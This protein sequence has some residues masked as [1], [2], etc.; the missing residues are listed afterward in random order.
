MCWP[1]YSVMNFNPGQNP[2]EPMG[3]EA[4][5]GTTLNLLL[6]RTTWAEAPRRYPRMLAGST[7]PQIQNCH[8]KTATVCRLVLPTCCFTVATF[9]TVQLSFSAHCLTQWS[10]PHGVSNDDR[11]VLLYCKSIYDHSTAIDIYIL[12]YN[13]K[14]FQVF[15]LILMGKYFSKP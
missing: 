2:Q 15:R 13:T 6:S 7:N 5:A 10:I 12:Q 8:Q 4:A 11:A 1:L 14:I 3:N 9:L